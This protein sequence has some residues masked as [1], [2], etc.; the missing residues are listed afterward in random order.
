MSSSYPPVG[1]PGLYYGTDPQ[2]GAYHDPPQFDPYTTQFAPHDP[3]DQEYRE[4]YTDEPSY[5]LPQGQ[6]ME[7][8]GPSTKEEDVSY[9]ADESSAIPRKPRSARNLRAWRYQ[10]GRRLWTQGSRPRC[11]CR[12][13]FCTI[14]ITLFLIAGIIL[15]L[16]LWIQPPN[17]VIGSENN[18][19]TSPVIAQGINLLSNGFQVNLGLPIEVIN[20][21][22]FT[23]KL[24]RVDA[25]IF[26]PI[27]NTR[28][29]NGAVFNID[30][31]SHARTSFTFPFAL[32]YTESVDP[33]HTILADIA[34]KCLASPQEDLT[35]NYRIT[36]TVGV[37]FVTVSPTIS[38][39]ITFACPLSADTITALIAQLGLQGIIGT[40]SS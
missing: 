22:Y 9:Y 6:S 8:L 35:V 27:N 34:T 2:Q 3:Y 12:F 13:F 21:N 17:I 29:G 28:V 37:F 32:V 31:Q 33:N 15:C 38:N 26:Y 11:I 24:K 36:V 14:L 1:G 40:G 18:N 20:P 23:V 25:D 4:P 10:Q 19:D 39:P 7:P 5:S 30:L 16:A